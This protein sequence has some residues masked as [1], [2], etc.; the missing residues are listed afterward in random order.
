VNLR[1]YVQVGMKNLVLLALRGV[2]SHIIHRVEKRT[3]RP[4]LG[5]ARIVAVS[6]VLVRE[7]GKSSPDVGMD[8]SAVTGEN[9]VDV[10]VG[11]VG[12]LYEMNWESAIE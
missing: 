5:T 3:G 2:A 9:R 6:S 12:I 11:R 4:S 10:V 7:F 8:V 1:N